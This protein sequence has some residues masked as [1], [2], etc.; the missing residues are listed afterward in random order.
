MVYTISGQSEITVT[1]PNDIDCYLDFDFDI[2]FGETV[3]TN[4][5]TRA[6]KYHGQSVLIKA[7]ESYQF[8]STGEIDS[9]SFS[10]NDTELKNAGVNVNIS[11]YTFAANF[12]QILTCSFRATGYTSSDTVSAAMDC[13]NNGESN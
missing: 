11:T 10:T 7:G 5:Q 6:E 8:R 4:D 3:F 12:K 2:G 13:T 9:W 1:N